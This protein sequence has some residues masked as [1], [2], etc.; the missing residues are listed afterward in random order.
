MSLTI[1]QVFLFLRLA[2]KKI[3]EKRRAWQL[4][5]PVTAMNTML[6]NYLIMSF[7]LINK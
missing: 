2:H 6:A 3:E 1:F 5:E 4:V 7:E